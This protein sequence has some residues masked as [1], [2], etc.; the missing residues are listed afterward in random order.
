[1]K[2]YF[3]SGSEVPVSPMSPGSQVPF[4][5]SP[6]SQQ[7]AHLMKL[8]PGSMSGMTP[9][10]SHQSSS[11]SSSVS[12]TPNIFR[13][14]A[15]A[16]SGGSSLQQSG[17]YP[18][19]FSNY[20]PM[21]SSYYAKQAQVMDANSPISRTSPYQRN[22]AAHA[23]YSVHQPSTCYQNYQAPGAVYP[24]SNYEYPTNTPR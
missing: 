7:T 1:M 16:G 8:F 20:G 2:A 13:A 6:F 22:M 3:V 11:S 21:Y 24:R 12:P 15:G 17:V 5:G 19:D 10:V 23:H 4:D 9:A 18:G 14:G